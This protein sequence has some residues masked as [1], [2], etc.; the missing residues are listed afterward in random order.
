MGNINKYY[1]CV[2]LTFLDVEETTFI[3][4][5]SSSHLDVGEDIV[6]LS[7]KLMNST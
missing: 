4:K 3:F 1:M 7:F 2:C 5:M 6:R